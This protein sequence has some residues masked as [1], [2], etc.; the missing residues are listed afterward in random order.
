[1]G[2][3]RGDWC[4]RRYLIWS[5]RGASAPGPVLQSSIYLLA[6]DVLGQ[7]ERDTLLLLKPATLG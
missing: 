3:L 4:D 6:G 5:V 7:G 1:M 2:S